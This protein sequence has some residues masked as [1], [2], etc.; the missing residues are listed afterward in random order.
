MLT[1]HCRTCPETPE[2]D[3]YTAGIVQGQLGRTQ[4]NRVCPGPGKRL[5]QGRTSYQATVAAVGAV[6][7]SAVARQRLRPAAAAA[8]RGLLPAFKHDLQLNNCRDI[9]GVAKK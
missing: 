4:C 8:R 9:T 7:V 2:P 3:R 1:G 5:R 6:V